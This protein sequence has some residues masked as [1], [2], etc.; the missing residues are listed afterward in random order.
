[1]TGYIDDGRQRRSARMRPGLWAAAIATAL[2]ASA[3][4]GS[5]AGASPP[6]TR[7]ATGGGYLYWSYSTGA[8]PTYSGVIGRARLNGT[9]VKQKF[10]SGGSLPT[11]ILILGQYLYWGHLVPLRT[12]AASIAR[13]KLNG[14][15]VRQKFITGA[16]SPGNVTDADGYLYWTNHNGWIGRARLNG[17]HADQKFIKTA[18]ADGP[19]DVVAGSGNLYW[20]NDYNIGRAK[21][22][23]TGVKQNFIA[24]PNGPSGVSA[25]AV[26]SRYIYWT[27]ET[28]GTIGR[29][30]LNGTHV[31]QRFITGAS[32]DMVGLAV[33]SRFIYWTNDGTGRIGRARLNGSDVNER[34][35]TVLP[36]G[37]I[38]DGVAIDPC[39]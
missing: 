6:P 13:A 14:T 1:M 27:D 20:S 11:G 8:A 30:L 39:R 5:P 17:T 36:K 4:G 15:D 32:F 26:N 28:A 9:D 35:I 16:T 29:A 12:G 33:D 19:D 7:G 37:G 25:L 23:G 22:N 10:I 3:W 34:F 2:L 24:V 38:L 31:N 18:Q 21:L